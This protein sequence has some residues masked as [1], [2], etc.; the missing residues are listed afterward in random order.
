MRQEYYG[1]LEKKTTLVNLNFDFF[2][3]QNFLGFVK[4]ETKWIDSARSF[5]SFLAERF[6][7]KPK[8]FF[9]LKN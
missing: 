3:S 8:F 4:K 5:K 9:Y 7:S 6:N 2:F 1:Y